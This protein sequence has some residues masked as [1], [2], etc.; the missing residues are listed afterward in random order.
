VRRQHRVQLAHLG[1]LGQ[2]RRGALGVRGTGAYK[3][4]E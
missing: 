3:A 2:V 1:L 4:S